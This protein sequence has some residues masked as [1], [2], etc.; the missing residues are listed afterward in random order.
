MSVYVDDMRAQFRRMIMCHM[1]AD[2]HE[3][4]IAMTRAIGVATKW[5]QHAGTPDEHFDIALSKRSLAIQHGAIPIT[6][7]QCAA[8][9]KRKQIECKLGKPAESIAWLTHYYRDRDRNRERRERHVQKG[10]QF[11]WPS[12]GSEK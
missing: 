3:E 10:D 2:T 7:R 9:T 5:I 1:I 4:L 6:W 11:K 12:Q 8:M